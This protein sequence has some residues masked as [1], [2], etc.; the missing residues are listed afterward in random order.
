MLTLQ[1]KSGWG[2]LLSVISTLS[3]ASLKEDATMNEQSVDSF[4][5]PL[6]GIH[7][8]SSDVILEG[9]HHLVMST[10]LPM[11]ETGCIIITQPPFFYSSTAERL[12]Q[13]NYCLS[14]T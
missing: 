9:H 13:I 14:G 4:K 1:L 3:L 6:S 12:V 2:P 8:F 11:I 7:A 5:R 10:A